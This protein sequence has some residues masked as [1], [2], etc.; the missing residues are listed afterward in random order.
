MDEKR[1]SFLPFDAPPV[2]LSLGVHLAGGLML[3]LLY[4]GTLWWNTRLLSLTGHAKVAA[5]LMI[6]RFLALGGLLSLASL[7]GALPLLGMAL[8][9]LFGRAVIMHRLRRVAA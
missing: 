8:G 4:F 3:G 5:A 7:E 6:G 9:V 2:L 1:M